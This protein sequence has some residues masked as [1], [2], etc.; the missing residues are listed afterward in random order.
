MH[1]YD[2]FMCTAKINTPLSSGLLFEIVAYSV[3]LFGEGGEGDEGGC[4]YSC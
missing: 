1:N 2:G 4:K 3:T